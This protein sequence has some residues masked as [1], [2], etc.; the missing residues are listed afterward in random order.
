MLCLALEPDTEEMEESRPQEEGILG[1]CS[2]FDTLR[3]NVLDPP[4]RTPT[5]DQ[6]TPDWQKWL[7]T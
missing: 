2:G 3:T 4:P 7:S 6:E 1:D 5:A